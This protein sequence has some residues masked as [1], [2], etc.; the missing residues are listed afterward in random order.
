MEI[1]R[2]IAAIILSALILIGF[3]YFMPKPRPDSHPAVTQTTATQSPSTPA[4]AGPAQAS[5]EPEVV[6]R[7]IAITSDDVQGSLNLKGALLDD[8]V[9]TKY[10]ATLAKDSP[11]VRLLDKPGSE[12][13][14]FFV[15]GWSNAPGS[16]AKVPDLNTVWTSADEALSPGH[17]VTLTWDNGEG[18]IFSIHLS[19][20]EHYMFSAAQ[21]VENHSSQPVALLPFQRVQRA[22]QAPEGFWTAHE[23]PIAVMDGRL[24]DETYKNVRKGAEHPDHTFW[25]KGGTGGWGGISD[26]YWLTAVAPDSTSSVTASFAYVPENAGSYRIGFVS[27]APQQIMP[28]GTV[29]QTSHL[30]AGAKVPSLLQAYSSDLHITDFDKAIDFGWFSFLTRPILYL[31]HWL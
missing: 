22:Y 25:A 3:D 30:F 6:A 19:V 8:A 4:V 2:I 9:L 24:N 27:Q 14:N 17:P 20:D 7:R 10:R 1:K 31:L 16:N 29:T 11:L 13:P 23:G 15:I 5:P 26:K 18:L 28:N 12:H 21:A